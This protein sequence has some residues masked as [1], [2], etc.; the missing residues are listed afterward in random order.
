MQNEIVQGILLQ[1]IAYADN[2]YI[3]KIL[4]EK[5]GVKSLIF[6]GGKSKKKNGNLLMPLALLSINYHHKHGK[7]LATVKSIDAEIIWT[8][9]PFNPY[10]S[11]VLFFMN[12]VV[13]LTCKEQEDNSGLYHFLL[14]AT[15][16]LDLTSNVTHFPQIFLLQLTNYLGFYPKVNE[17]G[18]YFDL[19][20]GVFVATKPN[21]PAYVSSENSA[22]IKAYLFAKLDGSYCP[23][24][25]AVQRKQVLIDILN[26]YR[27]LFDHFNELKTLAVLESVFHD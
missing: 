20:E 16:I 17:K 2:D 4:T 19:R 1:K 23:D 10:K 9:I 6:P 18:I 11:G 27:V 14:N 13:S 8:D 5:E 24:I 21:H 12:E 7:D 3:I 26:Y 22:L 25:N 15:Q